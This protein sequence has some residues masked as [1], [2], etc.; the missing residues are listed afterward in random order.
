VPWFG[1]RDSAH[2]ADLL[3]PA[4]LRATID[5]RSDRAGGLAEVLMDLEADDVLRVEVIGLHEELV[6]LSSG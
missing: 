3:R 2:D 1:G 6:K 5:R 4:C